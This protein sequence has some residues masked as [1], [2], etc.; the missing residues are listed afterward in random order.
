MV[1]LTTTG[2]HLDSPFLCDME[3]PLTALHRF[4]SHQLFVRRWV[5]QEVN[6]GREVV[7]L[8]G[9]NSND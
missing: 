6:I 3:P 4:D 2:S 7:I 8:C 9:S 1:I 5:V